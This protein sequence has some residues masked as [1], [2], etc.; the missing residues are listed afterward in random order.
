MKPA[1]LLLAMAFAALSAVAAE[2]P[3][4]AR[5]SEIGFAV[6]QMGVAV[7]GTFK[8]FTS[9]F[10]VDLAKPEAARADLD[11]AIGS[12]ATGNEEADSVALSKPWLDAARFPKATFRSSGLHALG[13]DRYE[14]K[15]TLTLKGRPREIKVPL[16][17]KAQPD[18]GLLAAGKFTI[19]RTDFGIGGGEWN[20]GDIVA[21]DVAITFKLLLAPPAP[22]TGAPK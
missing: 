20:E 11:V 7:T 1:A 9:S 4:V 8:D 13:A 22:P 17:L 18:G 12:L 21:D 19:H 2:R 14:A 16:T 3:L 5:K 10:D 15:G 6:T